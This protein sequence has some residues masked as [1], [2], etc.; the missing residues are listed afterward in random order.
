MF[1]GKYN[2]S[3]I[4]TY[5]GVAFAIIGMKFAFEM[6]LEKSMICLVVAGVCDLFDG[7]VARKCKRT[8]EEKLF[9]IQ[10]DSLA[11]MVGF[12]AFPVVIGYSL[13][14]NSCSCIAA[15][16]LLVLCGIT[17]LGF[18]NILVSNDNKDVPVKCYKGLPVTSTSIIIPFLWIICQ[19]FNPEL[20]LNIYIYMIYLVAILYVLNIKI[21]K[22]KGKAYL[23]VTLLAI[24]GI[25]LLVIL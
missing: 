14:L 7:K 24:L 5:I 16:I 19:I 13:G 17:R 21:P 4:I 2:K 12:V 6:D 18:F 11:D 23:V 25:I 8:D 9:G 10:I 1:I 3:L 20:F 22:I 15:Y